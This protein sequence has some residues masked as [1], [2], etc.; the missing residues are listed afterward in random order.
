MKPMAPEVPFW[1][2]TFRP[3]GAALQISSNAVWGRLAAY[4]PLAANTTGL[5]AARDW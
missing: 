4:V 2:M 3:P 5:S 1:S